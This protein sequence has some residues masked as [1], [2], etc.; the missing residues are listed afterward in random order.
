MTKNE[1]APFE[2]RQDTYVFRQWIAL[3]NGESNELSEA[4][5]NMGKAIRHCLTKKQFDY[6]KE[7]YLDGLKM[8][9][10]AERR[11]VDRSTVS[12]TLKRARHRL[13]MVLMY[14]G[15]LLLKATV[16]GLGDEDG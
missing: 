8:Q 12:R 6:I 7:Y 10:I 3:A 4:K 1:K 5:R 11:G 15:P 14:S 13:K 16:E 2:Y 9:Q